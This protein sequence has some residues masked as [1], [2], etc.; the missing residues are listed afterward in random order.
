V[1]RAKA[2]PRPLLAALAVA[3]VLGAGTASPRAARAEDGPVAAAEA[4]LEKGEREK[5]LAAFRELAERQGAE[6]DAR[7]QSGLGRALAASG[8]AGAALPPLW[9]AAKAR[10]SAAD[11]LTLAESLLAVGE[12]RMATARRSIDVVPYFEDATAQATAAAKAAGDDATRKRAAYV[13]GRARWLLGDAAG[14]RAALAHPLLA[15]DPAAL[16]LLARAAWEQ[17]DYLAAAE[18]WEKAPNPRG[19]AAAWSAAK[20]AR[21]VKAYLTLVSGSPADPALLDEAGTAA[22]RVGDVSDFD[23]ALEGIANDVSSTEAR[24]AIARARGL[25]MERA[26]RPADA[27]VR[28]RAALAEKAD[29][30]A[31]SSALGRALLFAAPDD[32]ASLDEAARLLLAAVAADP[33]DAPA[34]EALAWLAAKD[35]EAAP[36][37]WP[38]RTRLARC[39]EAFAALAKAMPEDATARAEHANALRVSGDP[40]SAIATYDVAV[41]LNPFDSSIANDRGLAVLATGDVPAAIAAFEAATKAD[42]RDTSPRQNLGRLHWLRGEDDASEAHLSAALAAS[43]GGAGK[44][45]LFRFLLDR[46]WRSRTRAEVR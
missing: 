19:A 36:K 25:L 8:D 1:T 35:W 40:K 11:H 14:A 32:P 4:L 37:A 20:D 41:A 24:F 7:V 34:K 23:A 31:T 26:R 17:G 33:E 15:A 9:A 43:R 45:Q 18:A 30:A 21:A 39:V 38:D 44:P 3:A 5:A 2:A 10:G 6:E 16:D 28:Y 29:D 12:E 13:S 22:L 27:V 42:P 46:V